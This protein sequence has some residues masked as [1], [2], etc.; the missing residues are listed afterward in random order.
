MTAD[1]FRARYALLD[2]L[3]E[4]GVRT[5]HAVTPTGGVVM[6][7]FVDGGITPGNLA[8]LAAL[9][10]LNPERRAHVREVT[11]VDG[12]IAVVTGLLFLASILIA[13]FAGIVPA[14]ATAPATST[15]GGLHPATMRRLVAVARTSS[16]KSSGACSTFIPIPTI[17]APGRAPS[18]LPSHRMPATFFPASCRSL[19]HLTCVITG[20]TNGST[21]SAAASPERKPVPPTGWRRASRASRATSPARASTPRRW[22]ARVRR[23]AAP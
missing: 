17:T 19:G 3:A 9:E 23:T 22:P 7:H 5:F 20:F 12:S 2:P 4:G 8:L 21:A 16:G 10:R 18:Q 13:P 14:E 6:V 11:A 1:E 15:R